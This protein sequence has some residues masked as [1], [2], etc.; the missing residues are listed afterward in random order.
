[1]NPSIGELRCKWVIWTQFSGKNSWFSWD[2]EL[3]FHWFSLIFN[4]FINNFHWFSMNFISKLARFSLNFIENGWIL[5]SNLVQNW[6]SKWEK[7]FIQFSRFYYQI[8]SDLTPI[9]QLYFC[10]TSSIFH[11]ILLSKSLLIGFWAILS[12]I[13]F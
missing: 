7:Y 5:L 11:S 13:W 12:W 4:E 6:F 3:D 1:M 9:Q 8:F 10:I 2:F